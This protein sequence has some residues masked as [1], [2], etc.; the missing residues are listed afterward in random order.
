MFRSITI[1][2]GKG[3]MGRFFQQRFQS[4]GLDVTGLD[5]PLEKKGL[6]KRVPVS[7]L[8]LLA[9]PAEAV[10]QVLGQ[11]QDLL[12]A[13]TVLADICSVKVNPLRAMLRKHSGPVVGTHPLFGPCP[14]EGAGLR[15]ALVEGRDRQAWAKVRSLFESIG[16]APF[17]AEAEE[18]DHALAFIQ[19]LNFVST[20]SYLAAV[21]HEPA[22]RK[23]LTP[24]FERRLQAAR[25]MLTEDSELF[26]SLFEANPYSQDAVRCYRSYLNLAA[27][28]E[29][30]LLENKAAWWWSKETSG[31]GA[32]G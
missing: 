4:L 12:P 9:V 16:L 7:D 19:G 32:S 24:S 20:V 15:V 29:L 11:M 30:D 23:Y 6:E 8:V 31:G 1:I 14:E 13:S 28:G 3:A 21:T 26:Q 5:K 10:E 17:A 25:K 27:A 18:H 2:G 22:T